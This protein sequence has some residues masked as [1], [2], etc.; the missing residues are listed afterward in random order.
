MGINSTPQAKRKRCVSKSKKVSVLAQ[1][2]MVVF[3]PYYVS[4]QCVVFWFPY[5]Q[6]VRLKSLVIF[7]SLFIFGWVIVVDLL[8]GIFVPWF[9]LVVHMKHKTVLNYNFRF[10]SF[11]LVGS[12]MWIGK[13]SPYAVLPQMMVSRLLLLCVAVPA[14]VGIDL[15]I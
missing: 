13:H 11:A 14:W 8:I 12:W 5:F 10:P 4:V 2:C 7:C 1:N 3:C 15:E 6:K 9:L